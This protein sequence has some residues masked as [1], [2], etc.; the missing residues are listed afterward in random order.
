[1]HTDKKNVERRIKRFMEQ[2]LPTALY[3][4]RLPLSLTSWTVPDEPVPFAK[5]VK[6]KFTPLKPGTAWGKPWGTTWIKVTGQVPKQWA[7]Q[8][9]VQIELDVDLGFYVTQPGFQAEAM[10]YTKDG[11][12]IKGIHPRNRSVILPVKP[13]GS[14]DVYLEAA[15]NPDVARDW[16]YRPTEMG[17]KGTAGNGPLYVLKHVDIALLDLPVFHLMHDFQTLFGLM[18]V[19]SDDL[20]RKA[21]ILRA[22]EAAIDFINPD[23]ISGTAKGARAILKPVL[24]SPAHASAHTLHAVGHA[25]IDSAWLWPL[26][27]TRRKVARTFSNAL[28]L[29]EKSKDFVFAASSAQQYK[30]IQQDHPELFERIRKA[31]KGGRFVPIGGMWIE[32]DSNIPSGESLTRQILEGKRFF[33]KEFGIEPLDIWLPDSFGYNGAFPQIVKEAGSEYF[34]TQKISWNDTNLFPHHTFIWEGI[35]GTQIFTHFPPADTYN[36]MI[37]AAELHLAESKFAERGKSNVSLLPFGWGN[38]G[39]GPTRDMVEAGLRAQNLEGS[40]KVTFSSPERFFETAIADYPKPPVWVGELYL[41]LHRATSTTQAPI[42]RG[43]RRSESL[44]REVELWAATATIRKGVKYPEDEIRSIWEDILLLQFHDI[45]PGTSIT[46]VHREAAE[47]Y[48]Q[49]EK[50]AEALIASA[51]KALFGSGT[52]T[53][54]LNSGPRALEGTSA[55]SAGEPA[56]VS[57][58]PAAVSKSRT[59]IENELMKVEF[60]K[61]GTISSLFDKVANREL[62]P[63]GKVANLFQL[64]VDMPSQWDAW[65]VDSSYRHNRVDLTSLDSME[66][67]KSKGKAGVRIH[68][69]FGKSKLVQELFVREG[70]ADLEISFTVDWHEDEK[71]LKLAFPLALHT[72]RAASE[73]QYGHLYRPIHTNTNW[74]AAR[75]ETVAHRWVQVA[76]PNYGVAI[77]N[78]R[79]YGYDISREVVEGV[80][81]TT[82][83]MSILRAPNFPDPVSDRGRHSF[84]FLVRLGA[85]IP[86]AINAGYQLNMPVREVKGVAKSEVEPLIT[87]STSS[88]LVESVKLA[89]DGTGDLIVRLYEAEG[90]HSQINVKANFPIKK[91]KLTD[92]LERPRTDSVAMISSSEIGLEF[93]PFQ[94]RTVRFYRK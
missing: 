81:S 9:D 73:I 8:K 44:M 17:D 86:D 91:A 27:E 42:K 89:E 3:R 14:I 53:V 20:P 7:D 22:L 41:E 37:S 85:Q 50:R 93:K 60:K 51:A 57:Y 80:S 6:N 16:S 62:V 32:P 65:D 1:M 79:T 87:V 21:E 47:M 40:P 78:D 52:K 92:S 34:L 23:D 76:E 15:S 84:K 61:D 31:V 64:H 2:R 59:V 63:N 35:D 90:I 54:T 58:V 39:G 69:S 10:V 70:S 38:G 82:V 83:R 13:G 45:L 75:F 4:D 71:F 25:H 26:R 68:R 66:S 48:E 24:S 55:M 74:D 28:D 33:K 43:N 5:A 11:K 72:D 46:W 67:F 94:L 19:L 29:I 36:S 49:I 77:A 12:T 18:Q 88:V 30:W 56:N